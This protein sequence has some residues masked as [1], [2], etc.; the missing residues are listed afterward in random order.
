MSQGAVRQNAAQRKQEHEAK[1]QRQILDWITVVS[2][3][4]GD[5]LVIRV[6]VEKFSMHPESAT[7]EQRE[8]MM[9]AH[10]MMGVL[11]ESVRANGIALG[12]AAIISDEMTLEDLPPPWAKPG[13]DSPVA[14]ARTRIHL[15]PGTKL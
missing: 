3:K 1:L 9:A 14:V 5:I 12:G 10:Q 4:R 15:P 13:D 6:P 8:T 11:V 2:P 7:P